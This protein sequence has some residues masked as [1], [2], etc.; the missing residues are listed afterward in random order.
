M[1]SS[2][3]KNCLHILHGPFPGRHVLIAFR[4]FF[5][6]V[7]SFPWYSLIIFEHVGASCCMLQLLVLKLKKSLK[8][9]LSNR[10]G[11]YDILMSLFKI[12][13]GLYGELRHS[14]AFV[15]AV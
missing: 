1:S 11:I 10:G 3:W 4:K 7:L 13:A 8:N 2:F 12:V 15:T 5:S 9:S 14:Y 6:Y